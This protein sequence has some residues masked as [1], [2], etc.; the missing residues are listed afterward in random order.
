MGHNKRKLM[1]RILFFLFLLSSFVSRAQDAG[2][3]TGRYDILGSN[4]ALL[5]QADSTLSLIK[6]IGGLRS[7][8]V[9]SK[10]IWLRDGKRFL[11]PSSGAEDSVFT[12]KDAS[13][14]T[15]RSVLPNGTV[16]FEWFMQAFGSGN[17]ATYALQRAMKM[18]PRG[19]TLTFSDSA[20]YTIDSMIVRSQPIRIR[21]LNNKISFTQNTPYCSMFYFNSDSCTWDG[22]I[23]Y[24]TGQGDEIDFPRGYGSAVV[25]QDVQSGCEVTHA[26]IY[27]CGDYLHGGTLSPRNAAFGT[28]GKLTSSAGIYATRSGGVKVQ[29]NYVAYS[30]TGFNSD[31][32]QN[33][34][35]GT[36]G[37]KVVGTN[38]ID[39]NVF[40]DDWQCVVFDGLD[41]AGL[42]DAFPGWIHRNTFIKSAAFTATST[43]G[44]IGV[45]I[46][47]N[48]SNNGTIVED[49]YFSG[50]W[51]AAAVAQTGSYNT[52]FTNNRF[53]SCYDC[54]IVQ[55]AGKVA[56]NIDIS[57]NKFNASAHSDMTLSGVYNSQIYNNRSLNG[58]GNGIVLTGYCVGIDMAHNNIIKMAGHAYQ[59]ESGY[60]FN[61]D[62]GYLIDVAGLSGIIALD[63][64]VISINPANATGVLYD[65]NIRNVTFD[66]QAT[67]GTS[68]TLISK[69]AIRA[70]NQWANSN[71]FVGPGKWERNYFGRTRVYD[72]A[73]ERSYGA[74]QRGNN[75]GGVYDTAV[76]N[77]SD[78][79]YDEN[80]F[81]RFSV[82]NTGTGTIKM[83]GTAPML[84]LPDS[85]TVQKILF[86]TGGVRTNAVIENGNFGSSGSTGVT[87]TTDSRFTLFGQGSTIV[88]NFFNGTTGATMTGTAS[89]ARS[90]FG[91][92]TYTLNGTGNNVGNVAIKAP[93]LV[94][95]TGTAAMGYG[96]AIQGV[97]TLGTR[98][99]GLWL[100]SSGMIADGS[101]P[102]SA[103]P[104]ND[105]A[106]SN[107][108]SSVV[109]K[110]SM[111]SFNV[112]SS[113]SL[114]LSITKRNYVFS[115]ST[116]T[117]WTMPAVSASAGNFFFVKNRG[118]ANITLTAAGA[119][120]MYST[121][122]AATYVV[123]P[124]SAVYIFNDGVYW[125]IE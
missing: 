24:Q 96:L 39:H 38:D 118:S 76:A 88:A 47:T 51:S 93:T 32:Y 77:I 110:A 19:F 61:V 79:R 85:T 17:N 7:Q 73:G 22:G 67:D 125:L 75:Y 80:N 30:I 68:P 91:S 33:K 45:K 56:R 105:L 78:V 104:G 69:V 64:A 54:L 52:S 98:N 13:G 121:S 62:G 9:G 113:T 82:S 34:N 1:K 87:T 53:D 106:I 97:S 74:R 60:S 120:N 102:F 63:T 49:N 3:G 84:T 25:F 100:Y 124:G 6:T 10:T 109:Q 59:F 70:H 111:N 4:P 5:T 12:F 107:T 108:D 86:A 11:L 20:A 2:D 14:A 23:F 46:F 117:V 116:A 57:T 115:G 65:V 114:T 26:K 112:A 95:G 28:T 18:M 122:A 58:R 29:D 90:D 72:D 31:G 89:A 42:L 71:T 27:Y 81:M 8:A 37:H 40:E 123:T 15:F 16:P 50:R 43:G 94:A 99:T 101:F 55:N 103:T 35:V 21:V 92:P 44:T 41:S 83:F 48:N 66:E 36:P 119:D